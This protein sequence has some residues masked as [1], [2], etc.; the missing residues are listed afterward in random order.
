MTASRSVPIER[1]NQS[2]VPPNNI[3]SPLHLCWDLPTTAACVGFLMDHVTHQQDPDHGGLAFVHISHPHEIK[4]KAN[5]KAIRRHVM[6]RVGRSRRKAPLTFSLSVNLL[7]DE[8]N[9]LDRE[10][11]GRAC[12]GSIPPSLPLSG[13]YPV[14]VNPRVLQ[15][16]QFSTLPSTERPQ[17][18]LTVDSACRRRLPLPPLPDTMVFNGHC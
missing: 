2:L 15:L 10:N 9:A 5:Q 12:W 3:D 8:N 14:T 16:I 13:L 18:R 1:Q 11:S 4:Q 7:P 17:Q 6:G